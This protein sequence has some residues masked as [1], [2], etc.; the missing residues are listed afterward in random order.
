ML[1]NSVSLISAHKNFN[2]KP[3][4]AKFNYILPKDTVSFSGKNEIS[5]NEIINT[6]ETAMPL[7][8]AGFKGVVYKY[9]KD[10]KSYVI[11]VARNPEFKFENEAQTLKQVP[12]G[13]NCQRFVTYF[14]HP[15]SNCDI[16]LSTFVDGEKRVLKNPKDFKQF[17][18][19]LLEL[20]KSGVLHGDLNMQNCLFSSKGIGLIDFGEGGAFKTGD[21]FDGF[22]Y[23]EFVLKSNV[24]NLEHNGIPDCIQTWAKSR[25]NSKKY[26][27][28]YLVAKGE[29]YKRHAQFLETQKKDSL[30]AIDFEKNYS[31]VLKNPSDLVIE[32][33]ARRIDC[34]YTFEHSDTAVNYRNIPS[35]AIR[36]W[37]LT[38]QKAKSQL[39]F[40]NNVL[41]YADLSTEER[42][43]FEYQEKIISLFFE[44]FSSWSASTTSWL[45][46]LFER[47]DLSDFEKKFIINKDETMPLPPNLV[48]DILG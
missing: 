4:Q 2:K 6:I 16:L 48:K 8:E 18:D 3:A 7:S 38:V 23:P 14:Q 44:Q 13:I 31:K 25:E 26:F 30:S 33:E 5:R 29:Y 39:D 17:F 28:N 37:D 11:K 45:N 35:A 41:N 1:I 10:N 40:I 12:K 21:T 34:L 32:N 15:S 46:G 22:I 20:D 47:D 43:Y 27:K 19:L 9:D 24:V 36:N 42:K